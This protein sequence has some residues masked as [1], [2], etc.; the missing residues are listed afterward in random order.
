MEKLEDPVALL[1][2]DNGKYHQGEV[3][4]TKL[5]KNNFYKTLDK[6]LALSIYLNRFSN[7]SWQFRKQKNNPNSQ[8]TIN[9][10]K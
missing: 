4:S 9:E 1:M 7:T 3:T 6:Y 2:I 8:L 5:N 10:E